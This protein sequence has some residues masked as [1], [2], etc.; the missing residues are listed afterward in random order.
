MTKKPI[1]I[2]DLI[3]R[4]DLQLTPWTGHAGL[5]KEISNAEINRPGL[6]LAGFTERFTNNRLQILGETE[7]TYLLSLAIEDRRRTVEHILALDVPCMI[8][9]KGM[10]PPA[11]LM[12]AGE[13]FDTAILGSTLTTDEFSHS[14]IEYLEPYFAPSTAVHG[15]LVDVYGIGLLFTGRSGIGKSETALDLVERGHRLVAD[16]VVTVYRLRRGVVIGTGNELMQH[17]ME[18]RGVGLIDIS[19]IF[20]IRGIRVRKRIEVVVELE[21]W[22]D[23]AKYDRTGLEE[24]TTTLLDVELPFVRIPIVPGKNLTVIAEVVA[25]NHSLKLV[26]VNSAEELNQRLVDVMNKKKS[27]KYDRED[28]E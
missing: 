13:R 19:S 3:K 28:Y 10:A 1:P 26:G 16:D 14:L 9:T 12:E 15:A 25:L 22:Q 17:H 4:A 23:Q 11:E 24:E 21:E 8:I 20:G 5:S 6:A 18:I 2:G 27:A 7:L